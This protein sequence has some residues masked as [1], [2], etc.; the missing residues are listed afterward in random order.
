[1]PPIED[2]PG[3]APEASD[4]SDA[5]V[6]YLDRWCFDHLVRDRAGVPFDESERELFARFHEWAKSG[7]VVFPLGGD[8]LQRELES[9][10]RRCPLGH[11]TG[12]GSS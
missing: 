3:W 1:M 12:H 8:S 11:S 6:V 7:R 4:D 9:E 5:L 10:E 2:D